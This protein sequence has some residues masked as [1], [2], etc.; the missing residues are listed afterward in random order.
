MVY[1]G[2]TAE[3]GR[4]VRVEGQSAEDAAHG[5]TKSRQQSELGKKDDGLDLDTLHWAL[6]STHKVVLKQTTVRACAG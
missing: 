3:G 1:T 4:N 2:Q 5:K 6:G